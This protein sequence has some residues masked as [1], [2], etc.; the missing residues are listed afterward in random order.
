MYSTSEPRGRLLIPNYEVTIE[1][2]I[3]F[4]DPDG[5]ERAAEIFC[6]NGCA[7]LKYCLR[8]EADPAYPTRTYTASVDPN[9]LARAEKEAD[10]I[11]EYSLSD[12]NYSEGWKQAR[13]THTALDSEY[14]D[15]STGMKAMSARTAS[16]P[17]SW[18][19]M[20]SPDEGM[21][22]VNDCY[23]AHSHL[24]GA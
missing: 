15:R 7:G 2:S 9:R 20:L 3:D 18:V 12:F 24:P 10:R 23:E 8:L 14:G 5:T 17:P 1:P 13:M 22:R 19:T 6:N 4:T 11:V 21:V 16:A